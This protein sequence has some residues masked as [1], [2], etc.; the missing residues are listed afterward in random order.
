L[1]VRSARRRLDVVQVLST[2]WLDE[3]AIDE[4]LDLR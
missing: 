4:I 1:C 3:L 2:D